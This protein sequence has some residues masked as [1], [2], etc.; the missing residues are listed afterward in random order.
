MT[1]ERLERINTSIPFV[2]N[3]P[4]QLMIFVFIIF[5]GLM[6]ISPTNRSQWLANS[7]SL[8]VV[9]LILVFT[10]KW[11]RFSNLSYLLMLIFFCLHTYAAHYTYEG[12]PF[13]HWLKSSFHTKRSYYDRIVHFAFGL[14][15][16]YPFLE[17]LKS[18]V[19]L[20]GI[21]SYILPVVVILGFS[22]LFEIFEMLAALIAGSNGE[23][24][25]VG[26][27]GD[28]FDTQKDMALAFL[29]GVVWIGILAWMI[30]KKE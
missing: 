26:M 28:V 19:K 21:W 22:A 3:K 17:I 14:L 25:F 11:F 29:G 6:A 12:T 9:I 15:F 24:K 4:L 30:G 5:F 27:Q 10:Y 7:L 18:K 23:A 20:C 1:D 8:I 13:D 16:T 2:R